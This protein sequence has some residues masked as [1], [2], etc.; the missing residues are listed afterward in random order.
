MRNPIYCLGLLAAG[1]AGVFLYGS[2]FRSACF[3]EVENFAQTLPGFSLKDP[4]DGE[5]THDQCCKTGCVLIIT[6][7]NVKHGEHQSRWSKWLTKKPWPEQGPALILIEDLSQSNVKEKALASMKKSFKPGKIPL[8]LLDHTGAV[9]KAL[10]VQNDETVVLIFNKEGK[11]VLAEEAPPTLESAK[12]VR[13][14]AE[15]M[16]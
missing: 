5:H 4:A 2:S 1:A 16:K 13:K 15:Q 8:L 3:A 10:R 11:L 9:R 12:K 6:I 7:P 14:F